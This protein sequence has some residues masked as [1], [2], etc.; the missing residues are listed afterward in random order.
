MVLLKHKQEI[1]LLLDINFFS[2]FNKG[3]IIQ[4]GR[5]VNSTYDTYIESFPIS[6]TFTNY[7]VLSIDWA[8]PQNT[9]RVY[10]Q[11]VYPAEFTVSS[12]RVYF[13][14]GICR[15]FIWIAIGY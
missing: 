2:V 1:I 4:W 11:G 13:P 8:A 9:D 7:S 12:F 10:A 3:I 15:G 14:T 6:F 5:Q